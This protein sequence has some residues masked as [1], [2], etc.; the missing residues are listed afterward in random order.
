MYHEA[1]DMNVLLFDCM[2]TVDA[3]LP[4]AQAWTVPG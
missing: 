1:Y 4:G 3:L 2:E